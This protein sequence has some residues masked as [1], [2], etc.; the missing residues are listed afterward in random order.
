MDR[1]SA[2]SKPLYPRASVASTVRRLKPPERHGIRGPAPT[3][4]RGQRAKIVVVPSSPTATG[5]GWCCNGIAANPELAAWRFALQAHATSRS[6][7]RFRQCALRLRSSQFP[8]PLFSQGAGR[9]S[10]AHGCCSNTSVA[11]R[12]LRPPL[13]VGN[14]AVEWAARPIWSHGAFEK[15]V[16]PLAQVSCTGTDN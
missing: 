6:S 5:R 13:H 10:G 1:D 14:S 15:S 4:P 2:R 7:A 16:A 3:V 8:S 9:G 11:P 12:S